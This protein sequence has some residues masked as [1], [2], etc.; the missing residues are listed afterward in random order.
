MPDLCSTGERGINM[1]NIFF[2]LVSGLLFSI[3]AFSRI[4]DNQIVFKIEDGLLKLE[5]KNGFHLNAEAP[6][7]LTY[8]RVKILVTPEQKT[9]KIFTFPVDTKAA[10]ANLSYYVCDDKKTVCEKHKET[11]NLSTLTVA[12]QTDES[13]KEPMKTGPIKADPAKTGMLITDS[14][15]APGE[16]AKEELLVSRNGKPT[17]LVFSAPWCPACIRMQTET[18][19]TPAV[20]EQLKKVNFVKL[21]SDLVENYEL[22]ERFHVKAIPTLILLNS[23]GQEVYRWLDY[24]PANVFATSLKKEIKKVSLTKD[25][26]ESRAS[27]G[28]A[29]AISKIGALYYN[30]LD[31]AQ[32]VKWF[33]LSKKPA[34]RMLKLA[35]E[36]SCAQDNSEKDEKAMQDYLSTLEK[37]IVMASSKIDQLRWTV[38]WA[39]K[40]KELK[41]FTNETKAKTEVALVDLE[42]RSKNLKTL[43]KE[44]KESTF[45]DSAG[46][47]LAE[48]H[49]MRSRL[50]DVLDLKEQKENSDKQIREFLLKKNLSV[51]RPGE[52]LIAIA[53]L[54]E[55]GEKKK[56]DELYQKLISNQPKTYVYHEKYARYLLKEKSLDKSLSEA[57]AALNFS[58]GNEPQ[59]YLLKA[60]I[61]KEM[62]LKEKA[63]E[64]VNL[65]TQ[66]KDIQ[67]ARFKK[68]LAQLNKLKDEVT[69]K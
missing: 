54:R 29:E 41:Q 2:I 18:Y 67:H 46:F 60:R 51:K 10:V 14:S 16:I 45:G 21:N 20:S 32:A 9:E 58:E 1:K 56:V 12:A 17:L 52:M 62:N 43:A 22:S 26:L 33:S 55:A 61:L 64:I 7:S 57:E 38:D 66:H 13:A 69:A 59:L 39:E 31:C 28:D 27:L 44:F 11:L 25:S 49:L 65:A 23:E 48:T 19:H 37:A 50:F 68:T 36:V 40:K 24:Q 8:P 15:K 42:T 63:V 35:A 3:N 34:D 30:A 53:Y 47:E 6:A 4:T 5:P